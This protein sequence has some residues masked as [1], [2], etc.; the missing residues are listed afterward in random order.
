LELSEDNPPT[1][2]VDQVQTMESANEN[3][4]FV[5][6]R[7]PQKDDFPTLF[8]SI[9]SVLSSH[10]GDC[11]VA[12]EAQLKEGTIVRIKANSALRVKRS[13]DLEESLKK[14]GCE[15]TIERIPGQANFT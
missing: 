12:V 13:R 3:T 5:V 6:L 2:I 10:P 1:I 4:E 7:A 8:D 11:N 15:L 9:L 14:L